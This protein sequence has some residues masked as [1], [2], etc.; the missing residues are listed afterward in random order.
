M[1]AVLWVI[2][3]LSIVTVVNRIQYTYLELNRR[4]QP[5]RTGLIGVLVRAFYWTDER[6]TLAYDLWVIAILA[7]VWLTPPD[8]L[9]DPTAAGGQ[10]LIQWLI[11]R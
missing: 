8:W 3:V 5:R 9:N 1:A 11:E 4:P 7:F 2:G 6:A 10:G